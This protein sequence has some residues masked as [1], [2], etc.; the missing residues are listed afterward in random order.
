M[1]KLW[2]EKIRSYLIYGLIFFAFG[3]LY[4]CQTQ[5]SDDDVQIIWKD[6][7]AVQVSFSKKLIGSTPVDSLFQLIEIQLVSNSER[8][9]ILGDLDVNGAYIAFRPLIPFTH[10]LQYEILFRNKLLASFSIPKADPNDAPEVVAIFPSQ[11][12]LPENLLK[13]YIHFSK[14]MRENQSGKYVTLLKNEHDTIQGAFLNLI[15]ELWNEDRSILTLWLDPGRI[16]RDLQPNL[17]LGAPLQNHNQYKI[18]VSSDWQNQ[19]GVRLSKNFVKQFTTAARDSLSPEPVRWKTNE[20]KA[21]TRQFLKV[22]FGEPLDQGLLSE[23]L[24][25]QKLTKAGASTSS[26]DKLDEIN[27]EHR[28]S[29]KGKWQIGPEETTAEFTPNNNW[30]SGY[31]L[32]RVETRLEDL[33]GNN[34]NRLFEKD[35]SKKTHDRKPAKYVGVPFEVY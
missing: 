26:R 11:D 3:A 23:T 16:K 19:E 9:G 30:E 12:T 10:G 34:I 28:V 8:V 27:D 14:P 29:I 31:Y 1:I 5:T 2:M 13:I 21:G 18:V 20:P 6:R 24:V 32:I 33:A 15:P 25:V 22:E 17:S 7:K 4:N 35:I